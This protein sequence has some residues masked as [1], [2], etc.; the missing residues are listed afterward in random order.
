MDDQMNN[1]VKM[2]K[3]C[4]SLPKKMIKELRKKPAQRSL[5]GNI[6]DVDIN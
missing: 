1:D 3:L 2:N 6:V 5:S 4:K